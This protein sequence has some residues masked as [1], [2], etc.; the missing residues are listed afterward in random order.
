MHFRASEMYN[1][2]FLFVHLSCFIHLISLCVL[3]LMSNRDDPNSNH[4]SQLRVMDDTL[5]SVARSLR[6]STNG[7]YMHKVD[8]VVLAVTVRLD[9]GGVGERRFERRSASF[10]MSYV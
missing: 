7:M 3:Q 2:V 8:D 9:I 10:G 5:P 1:P 4:K 6:D